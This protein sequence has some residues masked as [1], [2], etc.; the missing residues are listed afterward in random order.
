MGVIGRP[1]GVRGLV[2]VTSYA[3]APE[4]LASHPLHDDRGRVWRLSWRGEGI[5]LLRDAD[6]REVTDRDVAAGLTNLGL[7]IDRASLPAPDPDEFYLAD[8][9]GMSAFDPGGRPLGTV[10]HVHDYGAGASLEIEGEGAPL[11]VA[12]TR[13]SVPEIDAASRRLTVR[14]PDE[15]EWHDAPAAAQEDV[16]TD[17]GADAR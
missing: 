11:L 9:I 6:G 4:L 12:F 2:R 5:A 13:A 14:P 17:V 16:G 10:R 8:L 7:S 3:T 15:I 1:H